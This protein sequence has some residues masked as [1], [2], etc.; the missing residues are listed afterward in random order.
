MN[1]DLSDDQLAIRDAVDALCADFGPD[2]WLERDRD[3]RWP[4][5]FCAAVAK[6]GRSGG[7]IPKDPGSAGLGDFV[8][9][10]VGYLVL[11]CGIVVWRQGRASVHPRTRAAFGWMAAALFGQVVLGIVTVLQSAPM[12]LGLAH[13]LGAIILFSLIIRA[14]HRALYP[15]VTS[16]RDQKA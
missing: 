3:G 2:Y 13:Q 9:R 14:R 6:G 10:I 7:T 12:A 11:A 5:E 4:S 15:I 16:V 8:C 1:F